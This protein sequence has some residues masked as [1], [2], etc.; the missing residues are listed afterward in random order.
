ME[1]DFLGYAEV[2]LADLHE[3][4]PTPMSL[5]LNKVP[6]TLIAVLVLPL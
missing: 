3:D 2:S 4:E 6:H 5:K 1:D